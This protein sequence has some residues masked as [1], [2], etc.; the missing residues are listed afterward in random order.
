M[1]ETIEKATYLYRKEAERRDISF[2]LQLED[3]PR[4]VIGDAKKIR[5]VVQNL[6]ANSC[7]SFLMIDFVCVLTWFPVNY[8][9]KG[10]ITVCCT[11]FGEPE[12][13]RGP[14]QMAVEI[15]VADTGCGIPPDKLEHI[16]R[17][18]EQVESSGPKV[19]EDSGVGE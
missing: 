19:G 5:T 16:F 13:L 6:S 4:I 8:T 15:L 7:M 10:S 17:E 1:R 12:G 11:T 3:S 2:D 18:F 9:S 14:Q